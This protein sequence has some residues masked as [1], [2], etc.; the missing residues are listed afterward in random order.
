[1]LRLALPRQPGTTHPH[2]HPQAF[3]GIAA[4]DPAG[5]GPYLAQPR[6]TDRVADRHAAAAGELLGAQ[7]R[8]AARVV[9]CDRP[10]DADAAFLPTRRPQLRA[11]K[12]LAQRAFLSVGDF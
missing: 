8:P 11:V 10:H 6:R 5:W 4:A 7:H 12:W 1:M 3:R 9:E 2:S